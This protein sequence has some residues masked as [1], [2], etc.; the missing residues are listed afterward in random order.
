MTVGHIG[1][2]DPGSRVG[3]WSNQIHRASSFF[4]M[5]ILEPVPGFPVTHRLCNLSTG[6][7][8]SVSLEESVS[9][10]GDRACSVMG[11]TFSDDTLM[12]PRQ[13]WTIE[14]SQGDDPQFIRQ[15]LVRDLSCVSLQ[16][17][18]QPGSATS[19]TPSFC[20]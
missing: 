16:L 2:A 5:W 19:I 6:T 11:W 9:A 1:V 18:I 4:Q 17:T 10:E 14:P 15:V 20:R 3:L 8:L 7:Y 13:R 12:G